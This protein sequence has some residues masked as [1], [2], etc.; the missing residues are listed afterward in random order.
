MSRFQDLK[1]SFKRRLLTAVR[2]DLFGHLE[3]KIS[4]YEKEIDRNRKLLDLVS[5]SDLKRPGSV[6]PA[7]VQQLLVTKEE[8]PSEQQEWSSRLDQQDPEPPHIKEEQEELCLIQRPVGAGGEDCGGSESGRK[9]DP[10][11][12]PHPESDTEDSDFPEP[13]SEDSDE[14]WEDPNRKSTDSSVCSKTFTVKGNQ[15]SQTRTHTREKQLSCSL[16]GKCFTSKAGLRYH[17]KTH[18]G[19]KPYSCSVCGKKCRQKSALTNH[20]LTHTREKQCSCSVCGKQFKRK[21]V[22]RRHMK[23]HTGEKP[24]SCSVC[25]NKFADKGTLTD[26]MTRHTGKTIQV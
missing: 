6:C 7:D 23:T 19:E 24:F 10:D 8:V 22:L 25:G 21:S 1:D 20:M 16:C 11:W 12:D 9:L 4:E 5:N 15:N 26:H 13:E 17:L 14:D 18:T 2:K 3:R